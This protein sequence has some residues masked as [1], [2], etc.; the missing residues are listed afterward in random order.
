MTTSDFTS[1]ARKEAQQPGM[2]AIRLIS[3]D[4]L[5]KSLIEHGIGISISS[6]EIYT[7]DVKSLPGE[8]E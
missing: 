6:Q 8:Q 3:G 1:D 4:E 2:A 5:V 7:L